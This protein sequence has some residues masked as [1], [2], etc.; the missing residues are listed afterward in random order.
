MPK[1]PPELTAERLRELLSYDPSTG[2]FRWNVSRGGPYCA[3]KTAGTPHC[4]GYV[5]ITLLGKSY[6]AHRLAWLYVHGQWPEEQIDHVN[7]VRNQNNIDNL[8]KATPA[9]Q[10]QNLTI[11]KNNK[12]G[13]AGVSWSAKKQRWAAHIRVNKKSKYLGYFDTAE[14]AAGAYKKAKAEHHHFQPMVR[15]PANSV[16]PGRAS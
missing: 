1:N 6:L 14:E 11:R 16:S 4:K 8:R 9:E 3:G 13:Y 7:G 2:I 15:L 5:S 12:S 10:Q